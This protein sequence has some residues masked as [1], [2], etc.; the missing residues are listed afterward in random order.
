MKNNTLDRENGWNGTTIT[1]TMEWITKGGEKGKRKKGRNAF[2][3]ELKLNWKF[4]NCKGSRG[5]R[6]QAQSYPLPG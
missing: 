5:P 6:F 4:A 2:N 1:R 3:G